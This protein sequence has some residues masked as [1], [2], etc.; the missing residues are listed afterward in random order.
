MSIFDKESGKVQA[1]IFKIAKRLAILTV[2]S[3]LEEDKIEKGMDIES[4]IDEVIQGE[5][6]KPNEENCI[7]T[8]K[9]G[10]NKGRQCKSKRKKFSKYCS[11]HEKMM[12]KEGKNPKLDKKNKA[13]IIVYAD[14]DEGEAK[15]TIN[16]DDLKSIG[17]NYYLFEASGETIVLEKENEAY[18]AVASLGTIKGKEKPMPLS[19]KARLVCVRE[20]IP[21]NDDKAFKAFEFLKQ[22]H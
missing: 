8:L 5:K 7:A 21:T 11:R 3:L 20:R 12:E 13:K 15:S 22:R 14:D 1:E 19:S 18:E 2:Q 10:E 4:V 16:V 6:E 17:N 9:T